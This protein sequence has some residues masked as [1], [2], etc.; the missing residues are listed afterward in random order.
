MGFVCFRTIPRLVSHSSPSDLNHHPQG[1][2]LIY[3]SSIIIHI[4]S[5]HGSDSTWVISSH[6]DLIPFVFTHSLILSA[7]AP[8]IPRPSCTPWTGFVS[9][10]NPVTSLAAT[11]SVSSA[12]D[13]G[14]S[15]W[16]QLNSSK[17]RRFTR[18]LRYPASSYLPR[19][20]C[21]VV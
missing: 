16:Y 18:Q 14:H 10:S 5:D 2:I 4:H 3:F 11:P 13:S 15:R 7:L 17:L 12:I 20:H 1:R 21:C 6:S 9:V 19:P 8:L